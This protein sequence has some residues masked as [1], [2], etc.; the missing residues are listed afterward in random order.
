[1]ISYAHPWPNTNGNF[2]SAVSQD[3]ISHS[4]HISGAEDFRTY[5]VFRLF[6]RRVSFQI[7]GRSH[8]HAPYGTKRNLAHDFPTVFVVND[9]QVNTIPKRMIRTMRELNVKLE[10]RLSSETQRERT[11]RVPRV[12]D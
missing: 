3:E 9:A 7:F 2:P 11:S 1:M 5:K 6:H 12:R 10:F 8:H 4:C